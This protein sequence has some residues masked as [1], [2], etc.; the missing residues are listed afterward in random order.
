VEVNNSMGIRAA[1]VSSVVVVAGAIACMAGSAWAD[2]DTGV[3]DADPCRICVEK[4]SGEIDPPTGHP[5]VSVIPAEACP[6][7]YV[8]Y[9]EG[10][11]CDEVIACPGCGYVLDSDPRSVYVTPGVPYMTTVA[12][13]DHLIYVDY[14]ELNSQTHKEY[15]W[16]DGLGWGTCDLCTG[17]GIAHVFDPDVVPLNEGP[18][19]DPCEQ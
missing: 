7:Y 8:D 12:P 3:D 19:E 9:E 10:I 18:D 5:Y 17:W 13:G 6:P 16:N 1:R 14:C 15:W 2:C 11:S 4:Y